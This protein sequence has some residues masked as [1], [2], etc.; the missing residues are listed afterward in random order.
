MA[1]DHG[2]VFDRLV[3]DAGRAREDEFRD[4]E[5]AGQRLPQHDDQQQQQPGRPALDVLAFHCG[6]RF[7]G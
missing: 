3:E 1:R 6:L 2:V 5:G 4:L 7:I